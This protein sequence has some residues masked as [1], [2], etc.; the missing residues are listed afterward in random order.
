MFTSENPLRTTRRRSF[1][2]P[3]PWP[4]SRPNAMATRCLFPLEN[5]TVVFARTTKPR[6]I[7]L[8]HCLSRAVWAVDFIFVNLRRNYKITMSFFNRLG[9]HIHFLTPHRYDF[10]TWNARTQSHRVS[11]SV[12]GPYSHIPKYLYKINA[13]SVYGH[14]LISIGFLGMFWTTI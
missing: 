5:I 10:Q 2:R 11:N 9:H 14:R 8:S 4:E 13:I 3:P 1:L 7:R 12:F 6:R